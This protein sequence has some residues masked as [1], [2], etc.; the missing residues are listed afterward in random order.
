LPPARKPLL[1]GPADA[2]SPV[3][4]HSA[5]APVWRFAAII[6]KTRMKR[7]TMI[8]ALLPAAACGTNNA[9]GQQ[10]GSG[11]CQI[12]LS[13]GVTAT[14]AQICAVEATGAPD[15]GVTFAITSSGL[16]YGTLSFAATL[17]GS[18]FAAGAFGTTGATGS[19]ALVK[20]TTTLTN[21]NDVWVQSLHGSN[22]DTGSATLTISSTGTAVTAGGTST[23][24][25]ASGQLKATLSPQTASDA[26][27]T[28]TA[29]VDF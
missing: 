27:D 10:V 20:A 25:S 7:L 5:D 8:A 19:T 29:T 24:D 11:G 2:T 15:A 17:P 4:Q 13:G 18:A 16:S 23:W 9:P 6:Q 1:W 12:F 14:G 26:G 28:V 3:R 22:P 21:G